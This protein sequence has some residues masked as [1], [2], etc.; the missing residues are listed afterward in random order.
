MNFA[1]FF[2]GARA[3]SKKYPHIPLDGP[4][5]FLISDHEDIGTGI[6]GLSKFIMIGIGINVSY[7]EEVLIDRVRIWDLD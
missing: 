4:C 6:L 7:T 5:E 1:D 3:G 2:N